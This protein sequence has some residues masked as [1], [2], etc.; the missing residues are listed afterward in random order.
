MPLQSIALKDGTVVKG[1]LKAVVD[2]DYVIQTQ[3]LGELKIPAAE[4]A[5]ITAAGL[6]PANTPIPSLNSSPSFEGMV[7]N[8]QQK[9]LSDPAITADLQ[10]LASDPE[11]MNLILDP[12]VFNAIMSMDPNT[13]QNNPGVQKMLQNPKIQKL[14][15]EIKEK[16][17]GNMPEGTNIQ[18]Q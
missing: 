5:S 4:I 10:A 9:Y 12:G 7:R 16:L 11:I 18:E 1:F 15:Q 13:I 17:G 2:G 3:N 6:T 14:M 8:I